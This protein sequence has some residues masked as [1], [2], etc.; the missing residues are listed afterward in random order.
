MIRC[1]NSILIVYLEDRISNIENPLSQIAMS[2]VGYLTNVQY[3][4]TTGVGI[5]PSKSEQLKE[6]KID[7]NMAKIKL[8]LQKMN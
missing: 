3:I 8:E 6:Y 2:L 5:T 4:D 1:F 7:K